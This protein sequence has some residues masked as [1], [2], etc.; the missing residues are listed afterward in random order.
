MQPN[1]SQESQLHQ[2]TLAKQ[3]IGDLLRAAMQ[4]FERIK[5]EA[6]LDQCRALLVKL[7]EDR[8]NLAVVGQFKRGKSSLM[9]AVIGRELL[10]T[11]LLPLTSAITTLC[12]GPKELV[13]LKRKNWTIDQEIPISDLAAFVTEQGN[14]GNEKGILEARVEMPSPFLRRG[15]HFIDTPGIGSSRQENTATTYAFLPEADA[16]IFVTSVEAPISEAEEIFLQD[17]RQYCFSQ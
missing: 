17:V 6:C 5:E 12:Y 9:N 16:V 15:I 10:P 13:V 7:A 8:F 1:N 2:Y 14:P 11:G 3:Q 4:F